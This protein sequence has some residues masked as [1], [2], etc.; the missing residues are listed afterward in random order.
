MPRISQVVLVV[1]I[2]Y[3]YFVKCINRQK[4]KVESFQYYV[5]NRKLYLVKYEI[6]CLWT[7]FSNILARRGS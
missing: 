3:C 1:E 6:S 7:I 5:L 4:V 2:C